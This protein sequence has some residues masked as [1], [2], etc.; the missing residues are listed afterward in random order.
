MIDL[1]AD[2]GATLGIFNATHG[3]E[4][5][6][7]LAQHLTRECERVYGAAG[8]AWLQWLVDHTDGLSAALR[9]RMA[10]IERQLV[11]E[12][13]L[14]Q[15][16]RVGR[17]FALVAAAGEMASESGITGWPKGEATDAARAVFNAWLMV[18]PGG[19]GLSEEAQALRQVRGWLVAHGDARFTDWSR[20]DDD[21]APK[22]M[23]RAGWRKPIKTTTGLEELTG[24]EWFISPDV[25]RSEV[26]KGI[27]ERTALRVMDERGHVHREGKGFTC[28]ASPPGA[29]KCR[30]IRIR[31][32]I[33]GD[34]LD[35]DA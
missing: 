22:T 21:H 31:S 10:V 14:G 30:V 11:P 1:P 18:R 25:F 23:N 9:E 2:A 26:C 33:L 3:H 29:H 20:A 35:S 12:S 15:V 13:A 8:R 28:S 5:G 27:S 19:T 6:G 24:W 7:S 16:Q 4:G 32:S 17:R 34:D